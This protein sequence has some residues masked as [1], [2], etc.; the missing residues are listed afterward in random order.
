MKAALETSQKPRCGIN[1]VQSKAEG[2]YLLS[3][4]W[5]VSWCPAVLRRL[6]I[7]LI[8]EAFCSGYKNATTAIIIQLIVKL[9]WLAWINTTAT[10]FYRESSAVGF[11]CYLLQTRRV[12]YPLFITVIMFL[13]AQWKNYI[14]FCFINNGLIL[15]KEKKWPLKA[16]FFSISL[17]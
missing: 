3:I 2:S 16:D 9:Q 11:M 17:L 4:A 12:N 15:S 8:S 14:V 13:L 5:V 6:N 1:S 7:T 10:L